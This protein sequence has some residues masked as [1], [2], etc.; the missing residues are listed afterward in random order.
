MMQVIGVRISWLMLAGLARPEP[1]P[2]ILH[3]RLGAAAAPA[4]GVRARPL[5]EPA[6]ERCCTLLDGGGSAA[7]TERVLP[8]EHEIRTPMTCIIGMTELLLDSELVGEQREF[9]TA[10]KTSADSLLVLLNDIL[11]FS[12]IEAGKMELEAIGFSLRECLEPR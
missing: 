10:V 5:I 11:D 2:Q 12:K 7:R 9:L 3:A 1:R 4:P 6:D 8:H